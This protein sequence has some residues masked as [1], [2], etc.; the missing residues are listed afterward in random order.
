M[1]HRLPQMAVSLKVVS[2]PLVE[3]ALGEAV[4][5]MLDLEVVPYS[6]A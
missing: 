3:E 2:D 1:A 6:A 5:L 4:G